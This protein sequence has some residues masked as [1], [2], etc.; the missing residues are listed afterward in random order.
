MAEGEKT[1]AT[2][3]R[4]RHEYAIEDRYEAGIALLG[5]EVKALRAGHASIA[6]AYALVRGGEAFLVNAQIEPYA[7][8]NRE[9]H[10]PRRERRLLLHRQEIAKIQKRTDE[11][12]YALIP[13]R[14]YFKA[15]RA[16]VE[17]GLG[18]GKTGVDKRDSLK[19]RD[20]R[21]EIDRALRARE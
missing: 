20:A 21:R 19:E 12:G 15:G 13:L 11:R 2:N 6:D 17:L 1:V 7:G 9:N 5:T 14:L 16:K 18:R 10:E 8:G 4:A 3:R